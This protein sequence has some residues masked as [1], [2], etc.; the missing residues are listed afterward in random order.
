MN[1]ILILSYS[2]D[3]AAEY[4]ENFKL[5]E[6]RTPESILNNNFQ[7]KQQNTVNDIEQNQKVTF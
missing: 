4:L 1:W 2:V 7:K 3:E 6:N 5:S